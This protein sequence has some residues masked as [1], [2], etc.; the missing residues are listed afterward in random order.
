MSVVV[1]PPAAMGRPVIGLVLEPVIVILEMLPLRNVCNPSSRFTP[2][3]RLSFSS[4][5]M[6]TTSTS[7]MR[8]KPACLHVLGSAGSAVGSSP[9]GDEPPP[10]ADEALLLKLAL[11]KPAEPALTPAAPQ[12]NQFGASGPA[13]GM[14]A[15]A[16][17]P[18]PEFPKPPF[19]WPPG[20]ICGAV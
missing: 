15:G 3:D 10:N 1:L 11:P 7:V 13:D 16:C 9:S 5:R 18:K 20:T 6:M 19:G 4:V 17:D 14:P 2:S 12:S 8:G